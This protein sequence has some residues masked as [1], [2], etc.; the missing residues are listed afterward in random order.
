MRAAEDDN[1]RG[2]FEKLRTYVARIA[3]VVHIVRTVERRILNGTDPAVA[4][5]ANRIDEFECDADSMRAA[6][7]IGEWFKYEVLRSYATW[8]GVVSETPT[9]KVDELQQRVVE[10]L[11]QKQEPV[12]L[13]DLKRKF[14]AETEVIQQTVDAMVT[15][16]VLEM[17]K[18]EKGRPGP[19][20]EVYRLKK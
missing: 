5:W 3:L 14:R 8:G 16:G 9:P 10:F 17:N 11:E 15:Q 6:V 7:V 19:R 2:A 1:V 4:P 13:R 12:T 18:P 20:K